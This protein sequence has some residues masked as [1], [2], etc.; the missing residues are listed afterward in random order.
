MKYYVYLLLIL[1]SCTP[2]DQ[3]QQDTLPTSISNS[4]KPKL[5]FQ[6]DKDFY[7]PGDTLHLVISF[8][9]ELYSQYSLTSIEAYNHPLPLENNTAK[10]NFIVDCEIDPEMDVPTQN[11][12]QK[13]IRFDVTYF[14]KQQ[15]DSIYYMETV[16]YEVNCGGK[17]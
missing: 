3:S 12:I 11:R 9:A 1:Y 7:Q 5:D 2:K 17:L 4:P 15:K 14:N 13:E 8:P 10:M 16:S 6:K